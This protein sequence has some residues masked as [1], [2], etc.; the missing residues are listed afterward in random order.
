[1]SKPRPAP[2]PSHTEAIVAF[3]RQPSAYPDRPKGVEV[4]ETH[5]AWVFLTDR[6]AYKLKKPVRFSYLDYGT[7]A[8]RERVC[9]AEVALNSRLSPWVYLGVVPVL[10]DE[11]GG[12][13]LG[14]DVTDGGA[15]L[16]WLVKMR[17]LPADS[18]LEDAIAAGGPEH[19]RLRPAAELLAR[20]YAG[21]AP[22]RADA[23]RFARVL[24]DD[25]AESRDALC[26]AP[27]LVPRRD[28]ERAVA[29]LERFVAHERPLLGERA[30]RVVEG[31]GDLRPEH[32]HLGPPPAVIDCIEFN[33]R[34]RLNDPAEELAFLD[35]EC[36]RLGAAWV[37]EIFVRAYRDIA[38]DAPPPR[39]L[40]FYRAKRALLRAKLSLWHLEDSVPD[41]EKWRGKARGYLALAGNELDAL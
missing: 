34:F 13:R 10:D 28:V 31:H 22:R 39:L 8:A 1:M 4:R 21:L 3:L 19:D 11:A 36:G 33:R 16:D 5:M 35:M 6:L 7:L 23:N 27:Q 24:L 37:G 30:A 9:R 40:A 12:L 2:E 20:F 26:E 41:P 17:R 25:I 32:V 18:F 15:P 14:E 29:A 38:G